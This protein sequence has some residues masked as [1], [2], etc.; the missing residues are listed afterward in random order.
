MIL[1]ILK[2]PNYNRVAIVPSSAKQ[3]SSLG[4]ETVVE[5]GA[6]LK[7]GFSDDAMIEAGYKVSQRADILSHADMVISI[8]PAEKQDLS[9]MKSGASVISMYAPYQNPDAIQSVSDLPLNVFS[10]DMIPRTTLAQSMDVLSSMASLAGYKA[11]L[12][13]AEHYNSMFPMMMTAAGTIPPTKVM[14]LGAGVAGLQAI[15]TA[16]RL[17]AVVEAFDTRLAAKEEVQ[18]LGASFVE[19]EG[20]V[21]DKGAGGYAVQQSEEYL[22]RQRALVQERALKSNIVIATAQVRGRKAPLLIT[23][24]TIQHMKPGSVIVDL[25]ASTGGNCAFTENNKTVIK[26]GVIVIGNSDL[27][28]ELSGVS[29]TLFANNIINFLKILVKDGN[30][31]PD[32][33]NEIIKNALISKA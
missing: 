32:E 22:A 14:I 21:D 12:K 17:G 25:A 7:A 8:S 13:A 26:N 1:G 20:A 27:A 5:S 24:D 3:L 23:E 29:S 10:M 16:K 9:K 18:S 28:D 15:A 31:I 4:I 30:I 33:T 6:G 2:E 11:V 19:V